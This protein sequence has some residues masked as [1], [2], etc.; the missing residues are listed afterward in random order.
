MFKLLKPILRLFSEFRELEHY[1]LHDELTG[2]LRRWALFKIL[3]KWGRASKNSAVLYADFDEFKPINDTYG[4]AVGDAVLVHF[5]KQVREYLAGETF[6]IGRMGGD[7]FIIAVQD[8]ESFHPEAISA[9]LEL[10]CVDHPYLNDDSEEIVLHV[11]CGWSWLTRDVD[12]AIQAADSKLRFAKGN[13]HK[14]WVR[15]R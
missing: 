14:R 5:V 12:M 13:K 9:G 8:V 6:C 11:S 2:A 15:Y 7:E 10:R 1:A 3:K 4:H